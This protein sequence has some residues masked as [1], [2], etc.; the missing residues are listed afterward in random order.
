M[1]HLIERLFERNWNAV[2]TRTQN[3]IFKCHYGLTFPI[4]VCVCVCVCF[5]I[6][7]LR[8]RLEHLSAERT[9]HLR[10]GHEDTTLRLHPQ[11]WQSG[12]FE[13][14]RGGNLHFLLPLSVQ[15]FSEGELSTVGLYY[16]LQLHALQIS[17][18]CPL[19]P[20]SI[21]PYPENDS[22]IGA[23]YSNSP[24]LAHGWIIRQRLCVVRGRGVNGCPAVLAGPAS[25]VE[26]GDE[27]CG[28]LSL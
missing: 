8:V 18:D 9:C 2:C 20:Y 10:P 28:G 27:L 21:A 13:R 16:V 3:L 24:S 11:R 6:L 25:A 23:F 17:H 19:T 26:T 12:G 22:F 4:C 14:V 7:W 15:V 1:L 5:C